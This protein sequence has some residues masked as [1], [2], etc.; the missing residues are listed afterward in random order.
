MDITFLNWSKLIIV[1]EHDGNNKTECRFSDGRFLTEK[2][3]IAKTF[4][5]EKRC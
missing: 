5:A 3:I 2:A 1:P 4:E